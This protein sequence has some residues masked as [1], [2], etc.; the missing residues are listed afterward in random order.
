MRSLFTILLGVV[1]FSANAQRYYFENVSVGTGL[2]DSKVY[3]VLQDSSGL[4]WLGTESG[5][6]NYDGKRVVSF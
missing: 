5:L 4:V 2:P 6:S 1:V 3:A